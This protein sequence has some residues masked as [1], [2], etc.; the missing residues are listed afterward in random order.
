[1][2]ERA[3]QEPADRTIRES[4]TFVVDADLQEAFETL[5]DPE[6]VIRCLPDEVHSVES[7]SDGSVEAD[8][9]VGVSVIRPEMHVRLHVEEA[10]E[11]AGSIEYAGSGSG[12]RSEVSFDGQLDLSSVDEGVEVNWSGSVQF[13]GLLASLGLNVGRL[14]Y[15]TAEKIEQTTSNVQELF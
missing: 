14:E 12:G 9:T 15:I 4:G 8:V 2:S 11:D 10:D 7:R 6:Q 5:S 13:G 1:M 3:V